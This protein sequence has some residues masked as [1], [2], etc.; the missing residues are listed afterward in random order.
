MKKKL[1]CL[2]FI[3]AMMIPV[4]PVS[5]DE[6]CSHEWDDWYTVQAATIYKKGKQERLCWYCDSVQT[7]SIA[8]LKPFAKL[9]KKSVKITV[10]K[11]YKLKVKYA[12]GDS[13]KKWTTSNKKIA[14]VS[15]SGRIKAKK[16]GNVKITV[17]LKSGKKAS[18]K[19]KVTAKKSKST[20]KKSTVSRNT[21]YWTPGGSVYH[22]TSNCPT[23]SRSK[24]IYKGSVSVCPKS[25]PCKVCF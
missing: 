1:L 24:V 3:C 14:T 9:S 13:V 17:K 22:S 23:L 5:A 4:F 10:G 15:K 2:L 8:K 11:T 19:V 25:R 21:V 20:K 18:C 16:K 12:K 6:S 7:R